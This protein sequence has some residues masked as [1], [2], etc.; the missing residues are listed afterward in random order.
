[1]LRQ[2]LVVL[3]HRL[4]RLRVGELARL[5][6]GLRVRVH[7]HHESHW[8]LSFSCRDTGSYWHDERAAPRSTRAAK[9]TPQ[10]FRP[11]NRGAE[12]TLPAMVPTHDVVAA[13]LDA[14]E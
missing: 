9:K 12:C 13:K 11:Q 5:V 8:S 1:C 6:R 10:P 14:I 3:R 4:D 2:L 7:E